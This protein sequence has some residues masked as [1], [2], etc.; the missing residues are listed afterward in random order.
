MESSADES[1]N[2]IICGKEGDSLSECRDFTSWNTLH[3]A[4]R[5][6][7]LTEILSLMTNENSLPC[8]AIRY[9]RECRSSFTHKKKLLKLSEGSATEGNAAV[10]SRPRRDSSTSSSLILPVQCIFCKKDKYKPK[11]RTREKLLSCSEFRADGNIRNSALKHINMCTPMAEVANK[12][13]VICS[14]DLISSEAKYHASCYR[15]FSRV[16]NER[17][18]EKMIQYAE[19]QRDEMDTL[20]SGVREFCDELIA[21]PRV[22]EFKRIRTIVDEKAKELGIELPPSYHNNLLRKVSSSFKELKF[23]HKTQSCILV[24]PCTLKMDDLVV[25]YH[26]LVADMNSIN[27]I[28]SSKEKTVIQVAKLL[29]QTILSQPPQMSWPP[30]EK[31]LQAE[32]VQNFIPSLLDTFCSTL[33]SGK[34]GT[35][36]GEGK[37]LRKNSIAQDI[38]YSVSNGRLLTPKSV[39]FP[40]VMKSL[41]NT[42]EV[43]RMLNK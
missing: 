14:K 35:E 40:T 34:H 21:S 2:C 41:C 4:A 43:L 13:L 30:K 29:H 39:I 17:V 1:I 22:E 8:L 37:T 31:E 25:K 33:L 19:N 23:V 12:I 42:T 9:H 32:N 27:Q 38:I 16:S 15:N 20:F 10:T 3:S 7:N 6:R 36:N 11:T 24:Y 5:I 26:K 18:E 28:S